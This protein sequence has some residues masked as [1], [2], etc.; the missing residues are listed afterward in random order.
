MLMIVALAVVAT[1]GLGAWTLNLVVR[2]TFESLDEQRRLGL[3][4]QFRRE[5]SR[6]SEEVA[7]RVESIANQ[8]SMARMA[9]DVRRSEMASKYVYSS[10]ELAE[11]YSL[12]FLEILSEGRIISSAQWPARFGYRHPWWAQG[13]ADTFEP[14][15]DRQELA[16]EVALG[17]FSVAVVRAGDQT[18]HIIGGR[19]LDARFLEGLV[20]PKGMRVFLYPNLQPGYSP[21]L[22]AGSPG[23]DDHGERL[24]PLLTAVLRDKRGSAQIVHWSGNADDADT[25]QAT[26]ILGRHGQIQA[27]LL[28]A[29][30]RREITEITRF[31]RW[32]GLVT[33]S[34]GV[35]LGLGVG[36]WATTRVTRPIQRLVQG[37]RK[38]AAGHWN[39]RVAL[40]SE[41]EIGQLARGFNRMTEQ[42]VEQR[43]RLVQVERVA[44]WRELARR[45]AHEIKNPLFPLQITVEN[46]RSARRC[47]P[48]QFEE[49]FDESTEAMLVELGNLKGIVGRFSEFARM[50]KP[51][52]AAVDLNGLI[53]EVLRLFA[54]QLSSLSPQVTAELQLDESLGPAAGDPDLLRQVLQ[55]LILNALD[56]MPEGGTLTVRTFKPAA[57]GV[58]LEVTDTGKG[59]DAEEQARIF[60]PYYTTKKHGTGLGLAIVQSIVSDH[61]GK[62]SVDTSPGQG[63]TFRIWLPA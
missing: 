26:P 20:L 21:G 13:F 51:E 39:T 45:M 7:R 52:M 12:D 46:L 15:L 30:S 18:L 62:V 47:A 29:S 3:D 11:A 33:A 16:D 4:E 27:V 42:L 63:T 57:G 34:G 55:N 1:A 17:I 31:I 8:E 38:V 10:G 32:M 5:F 40:D 58:Q 36:W 61:A 23:P 41:D 44:A 22:L 48:D 49:V 43:E 6:S 56:A 50:P 24:A 2:R 9:L 35:L 14:F 59:L 54:S 37:V 19:R 28:V 25:V 53:R 60:T